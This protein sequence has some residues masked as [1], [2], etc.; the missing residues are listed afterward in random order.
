MRDPMPHGSL[1]LVLLPQTFG[2]HQMRASEFTVL[3]LKLAGEFRNPQV[4]K[5]PDLHTPCADGNPKSDDQ[6]HRRRRSPPRR[7][8]GRAASTGPPDPQALEPAPRV[9]CIP[10]KPETSSLPLGAEELC[11]SGT[12]VL[13]TA[14]GRPR[15][16]DYRRRS[17]VTSRRCRPLLASQL[18]VRVAWA[19]PPCGIPHRAHRPEPQNRTRGTE[20]YRRTR[21]RDAKP[22]PG[23][24]KKVDAAPGGNP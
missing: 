14:T 17:T 1:R 6:I 4:P 10:E 11:L 8:L 23:P 15:E 19:Q 2:R 21:G 24:E 12:F 3:P 13:D 20:S 22:H 18:T 5:S 7:D 16:R 9:P